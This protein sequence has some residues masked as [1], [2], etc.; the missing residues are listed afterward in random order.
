MKRRY[1]F[2]SNSSSTSFLIV[3]FETTIKEANKI[4]KKTLK[5]KAVVYNGVDDGDDDDDE[6]EIFD[7]NNQNLTKYLADL[8]FTCNFLSFMIENY[9]CFGFGEVICSMGDWLNTEISMLQFD[10]MREE[11]VRFVEEFGIEHKEIKILSRT[12]E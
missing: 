11:I 6:Y 4:F 7:E 1:G 8:G 5:K 3:G 2:V 9:V 12:R 10:K